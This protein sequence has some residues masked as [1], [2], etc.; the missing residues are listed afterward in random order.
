MSNF[1]EREIL[2][3]AKK[4]NKGFNAGYEAGKKHQKEVDEKEKEKEK[5][6]G[7]EWMYNND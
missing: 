1:I 2:E 7:E 6:P 4:Y 5:R 3:N